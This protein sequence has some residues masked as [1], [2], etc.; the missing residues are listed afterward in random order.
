MLPGFCMDKRIHGQKKQQEEHT[1]VCFEKSCRSRGP[2]S[3]P[4]PMCKYLAAGHVAG[5]PIISH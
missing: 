4:A 5:T 1:A 3:V 2:I